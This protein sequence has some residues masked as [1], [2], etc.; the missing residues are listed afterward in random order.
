MEDLVECGLKSEEDVVRILDERFQRQQYYVDAGD[1]LV[2]VNPWKSLKHAEKEVVDF[3]RCYKS[4]DKHHPLPPHPCSVAEKAVRNGSDG[5]IIPLG[6]S[7]SGKSSNVQMILHYLAL[8]CHA[9]EQW[10]KDEI[11]A[12]N[13]VLDIFCNARTLICSNSTR[14]LKVYEV[15]FDSKEHRVLG[16]NVKINI[17]EKMRVISQIKGESSFHIFH[18][19]LNGLNSEQLQ[20]YLLDEDHRYVPSLPREAFCESDNSLSQSLKCLERIGFNEK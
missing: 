2:T 16:V 20:K 8:R 18:R 14:C 11:L 1:V 15:F 7:G 9:Q 13:E 19:L 5:V 3:L 6:E 12:I 17:L 10:S 4:K